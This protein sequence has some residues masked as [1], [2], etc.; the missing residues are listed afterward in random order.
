MEGN[1]VSSVNSAIVDSGTSLL[2]APTAAVSDPR[3]HTV[4]ACRP[5]HSVF[6]LASSEA[7]RSH[8]VT[9]SCAVLCP[10]RVQVDAIAQATGA[11]RGPLTGGM[12]VVDCNAKLPDLVF[13]IGGKDY[14]L[15]VRPLYGW[16]VRAGAGR[17]LR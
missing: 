14:A 11:R 16:A 13:T 4:A 6:Q 9:H 8:F 10:R 3:H 17:L 5:L 2:I 12:L 15:T 1:S 7:Q